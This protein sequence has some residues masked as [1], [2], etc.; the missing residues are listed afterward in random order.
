GGLCLFRA[1][2]VYHEYVGKVVGNS[3]LE[4]GNS[5]QLSTGISGKLQVALFLFFDPKPNNE[6]VENWPTIIE[7]KCSM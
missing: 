4:T 2:A 6:I 1:H 5:K 3:K 7:S